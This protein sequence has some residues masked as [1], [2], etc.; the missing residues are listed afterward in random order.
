VE[1]VLT[2]DVA[3]GLSRSLRIMVDIHRF[4]ARLVASVVV[5]KRAAT[6]WRRHRQTTEV[7]R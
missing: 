3:A 6:P 1:A 2:R 4:G 7:T 5:P